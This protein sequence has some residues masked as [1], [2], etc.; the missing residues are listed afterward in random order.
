MHTALERIDA[1]R[2]RIT[3]PDNLDI[4]LFANDGVFLD[5][6][7]VDEILSFATITDTLS[8][9]NARGYFADCPAELARIVLTPDFHRGAGIPVG[10]VLD[11]RGF[12]LPKAVGTDIGCGM[13][14][15]ATDVT[16]DEFATL[17]DD[18]DARLRH[19]FFEGGRNIALSAHQRIGIFRDGIAGLMTH[20]HAADG[21]W[22]HWNARAQ[23][24][25]LNRTHRQGTLATSDVFEMADFIKGS[26]DGSATAFTR[27]GQ[28][29][30][31]GGGNH[32]VELQRIDEVFDGATARSWGLKK[33]TI[34]IMAHSGSV[35]IGHLIGNHFSDAAKAAFPRDLKHPDHGFYPLP[36]ATDA[37]QRY[38]SAMGNAGNFAF[39]NRLFLGLMVVRALTEALGREVEAR[40]VYDAPHNLIWDQGDHRMIHRK[41]A[42]PADGA[43]D[44]GGNA[45]PAFPWGHPV[46]IPGSMGSS[47]YVLRGHGSVASLCSACHG[48]GRLAP[49]Q[50]SRQGS[51]AELE[52]LRVVTKVDG[53]RLRRDVR[54]EWERSLLEEAP[55]RYKDV[56]PVIETVVDAD[57]ASKVARLWPLL[58]IKGL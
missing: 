45:D 32:F 44:L 48:A 20:G 2:V 57:V 38:L 27:D 19:I 10:T 46:I 18:F 11:A 13:R 34:A 56:T 52:T 53:R 6:A 21:L 3:T 42:C 4:T 29:G 35:G 8:A 28:I 40:L 24:H 9:L 33:G 30:S 17:G 51:T 49:R 37:G 26:G 43:A 5:A 41:G 14:L 47:S 50:Q 12:V 15:L 1:N 23:E 58:T 54:E 31:I 39:A 55:S 36:T 7:S 25:D 16:A 22:E